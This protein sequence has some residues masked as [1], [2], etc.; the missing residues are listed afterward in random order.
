MK[1]VKSGN[2]TTQQFSL[3]ETITEADDVLAITR[4]IIKNINSVSDD[5]KKELNLAINNLNQANDYLAHIRRKT[6]IVLKYVPLDV[7]EKEFL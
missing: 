1:Y 5:V 7:K 6:G 4:D 3:E 2:F